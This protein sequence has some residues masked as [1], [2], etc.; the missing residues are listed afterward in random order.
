MFLAAALLAACGGTPAPLTH[1]AYIW[2]RQ[3]TPALRGSVAASRD[4]VAAWRVLAAQASR[5]GRVQVFTADNGALAAAGRPVIPVVRIDGRLARFDA[6]ALRAQVVGVLTRW[7]GAAAIEIDY[8]CPT[9]RL[10]AYAA[11]LRELKPALGGTRLSITALP[12]WAGSA[13]LDALL[14]IADESVLQVHAVQAPQAGL[15]DPAIAASWVSAYATHTHRPFRIALPTYGSRVSWND[16]G[17]LLAVESETAALAAGASA[18]ELYASPDAVMAFVQGLEAHRPE[19]LAGIVW[20]RLPTPDDTR[21]WSLATWRGV[22][23]G[24][25]DRAPLRTRLR[26]AGQGASDVLVENPAAT[27]AAAPSRV[28]LPPGCMLADGIDG[29]RLAPGTQPLTLVAGQARPLAAHATRAVGWARCP[30][31]TPTTLTLQ[32]TPVS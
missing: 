19:G 30:P 27:D 9:A 2:Q 7:P 14:A 26:D 31:G 13:D 25:L 11:F 15:F 28:A 21:A 12:T 10:P 1:E 32:G 29:Y 17:T 5:D 22:V 3:W 23:T 6:T 24:H 18:S 8:D 16:D 20:F 4:F